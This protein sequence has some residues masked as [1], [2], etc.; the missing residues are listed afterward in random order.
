MMKKLQTLPL[1]TAMTLPLLLACQKRDAHGHEG[2][3]HE[4]VASTASNDAHDHDHSLLTPL[5]DVPGTRTI[6]VAPAK[7]LSIWLPAVVI[8]DEASQFILSSPINGIIDT[9]LVPPGKQVVAGTALAEVKSPELARMYADWLGAKAKLSRAESAL[10]REKRL[11][12]KKATS[13]RDL[14]EAISEASIAKAEEESARLA[15]ESFGIR[16]E[17]GGATW[18]LKAPR[19]GTVVDYKVMSGQGV[20]AGQELGF[21]L[22]TGSV[23]VRMEM[24][25]TSSRDWKLGDSFSVKHSNGQQWSGKLEGIVPALSSDT[26]RQSY[27]LRLTGKSLPLPGTPVEV[28]IQFPPSITIPQAALQQVEGRWGVFVSLHGHA[29]FRPVVR[30]QDIK[31]EVVILDGL[32]PGQTIVAEGAYLLKAY[33]RKL[34]HP[35]EEDG[36]VH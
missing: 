24:A 31:G 13:Q 16:A 20:S 30:G 9:L 8:A 11:D 27:R 2:H 25:Q 10:E 3:N 17:Q 5:S 34:A 7:E 4:R 26:M 35:D 18:I 22:A 23:V 32:R 6:V 29:E 19:A 21:F 36:H 1:L 14:E 12:A 15:L 28:E 33:Q